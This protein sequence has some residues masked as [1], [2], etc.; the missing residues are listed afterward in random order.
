LFNCSQQQNQKSS[1]LSF[2]QYSAKISFKWNFTKNPKNEM[3]NVLEPK[4]RAGLVLMFI[5]YLL[6]YAERKTSYDR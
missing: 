2:R 4:K 5:S 6:Q 1:P 3:T